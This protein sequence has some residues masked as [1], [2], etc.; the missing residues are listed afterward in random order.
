MASHTI[1]ISTNIVIVTACFCV[2]RN[3]LFFHNLS[4]LWQFFGSI[5]IRLLLLLLSTTT[6]TM[7]TTTTTTITTTNTTIIIDVLLHSCYMVL[8]YVCNKQSVSQE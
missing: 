5:E 1:I 8:A 6:T 3:L 2:T 4:N 7:P